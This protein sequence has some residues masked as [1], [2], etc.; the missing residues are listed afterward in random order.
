[1]EQKQIA[2]VAMSKD[3]PTESLSNYPAYWFGLA[4]YLM[5]YVVT[6]AHIYASIFFIC[7]FLG[8]IYCLLRGVFLLRGWRWAIMKRYLFIAGL[9]VLLIPSIVVEALGRPLMVQYGT[10]R[11]GLIP[12]MR[13]GTPAFAMD[14]YN[15][16][17]GVGC[18]GSAER[19][20]WFCHLSY[21]SV[22]A[23]RSAQAVKFSGRG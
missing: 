18:Y 1:M 2:E 16:C 13:F 20:L 9:S 4:L 3:D 10:E 15:T 12:W 23:A 6:F 8:L 22:E 21:A 17:M 19:S 5:I 11:V 14:G 7:S